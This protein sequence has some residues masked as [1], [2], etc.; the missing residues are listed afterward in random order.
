M[1][2]TVNKMDELNIMPVDFMNKIMSTYGE[3]MQKI[4]CIEELSELQKELT[5]CLRDCISFENLVEEIAHCLMSISMIM[6]LYGISKNMISIEVVKK[7]S[8]YNK[9]ANFDVRSVNSSVYT[10][11]NNGQIVDENELEGFPIGVGDDVYF[12]TNSKGQ[13]NVY[14]VYDA[15]VDGVFFDVN[16]EIKIR[17]IFN[18]KVYMG[19][20]GYDIFTELSDAMNCDLITNGN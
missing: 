7:I 4:V 3:D 15:L 5:K 16:N 8:Q 19:K 14:D 6:K 17:V 2:K 20:Y 1:S 10:Q 9:M 11:L 13:Y 18:G 12:V